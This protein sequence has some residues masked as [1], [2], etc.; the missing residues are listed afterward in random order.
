MLW[1]WLSKD[2]TSAPFRRVGV[3]A[4][5]ARPLFGVQKEDWG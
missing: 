5:P 4:P 3:R 1:L 2:L